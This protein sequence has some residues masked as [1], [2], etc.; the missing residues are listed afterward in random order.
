MKVSKSS[1]ERF[2]SFIGSFI[3]KND[4]ATKG[5][6]TKNDL[7][8]FEATV[9]IASILRGHLANHFLTQTSRYLKIRDLLMLHSRMSTLVVM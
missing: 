4:I 6:L 3:S 1:K 2:R 9:S 5:N 7:S 8:K